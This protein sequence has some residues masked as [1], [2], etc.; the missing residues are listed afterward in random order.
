MRKDTV[1][2][3]KEAVAETLRAYVLVNNWAEGCV[4]ITI[5]GLVD[6][7]TA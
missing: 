3:T 7:M 4:P 2:L 6:V 1:N 5:Q